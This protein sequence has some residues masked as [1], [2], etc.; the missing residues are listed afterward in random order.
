MIDL[1]FMEALARFYVG[2]LKV[3]WPIIA[4]GTAAAFVLWMLGVP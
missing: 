3:V 2:V 1:L 4:V